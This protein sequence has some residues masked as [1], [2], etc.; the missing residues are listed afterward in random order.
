M[1]ND[2]KESWEKYGLHDKQDL[3]MDRFFYASRNT[4]FLA[5]VDTV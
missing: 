5:F 3:G 4:V 2:L 1:R